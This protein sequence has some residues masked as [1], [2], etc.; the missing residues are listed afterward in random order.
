MSRKHL[1]WIAAFLTLFTFIGHT[2]GGVSGPGPEQTGAFQVYQLMQISLVKMPFGPSKNLAT[3]M[4]GANICVSFFLLVS[5]WIF[6]ILS[7]GTSGRFEN[8]ILLINSLGMLAT[9]TVSLMCFFPLP[10]ICTALAGVLGLVAFI[11]AKI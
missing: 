10:A 5:G 4:M 7:N 9:G 11:R 3:I 8:Q 6:I 1:L 2:I